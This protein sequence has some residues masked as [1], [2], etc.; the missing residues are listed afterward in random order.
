MST[1]TLSIR[2]RRELREKMKRFSHIDWRMEIERFIEE[3]IREEELRQLL[4]RI[5]QLLASVKKEREP[6]WKTIR[7]YR[8]EGW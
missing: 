7:G 2:I 3:R 8:E 5:D 1:V 6:A 4:D